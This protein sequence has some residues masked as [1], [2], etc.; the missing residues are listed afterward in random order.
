MKCNRTDCL[1][2]PYEKCLLDP[3]E[4]KAKKAKPKSTKSKYEKY[5]DYYA[6]YRE[7][8]R[9]RIREWQREYYRK[10]TA[11]KKSTNFYW[12]K[13]FKDAESLGHELCRITL[14]CEKCPFEADCQK[15]LGV[16]GYQYWLE[17]KHEEEMLH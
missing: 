13:S 16:N 15:K 8:N 1:N 14:D 12:L 2:C 7:E 9:E 3:K 6:K 17:A 10:K 11:E 5:G 4:K